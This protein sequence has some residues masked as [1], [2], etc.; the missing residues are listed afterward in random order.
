M[1]HLPKRPGEPDMTYA[2]ITKIRTKLGWEPSVP[3][4]A[5]VEA[6]LT[7]IDLWRD[8]PVWDRESITDATKLWFKY[9]G[10]DSL[11]EDV[12]R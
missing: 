9:L 3:F 4:E 11:A 12:V 5:G 6:M 7:N 1:E 10:D 8:A 2:D